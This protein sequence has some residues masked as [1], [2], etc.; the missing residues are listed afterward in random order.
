MKKYLFPLLV[1]CLFLSGCSQNSDEVVGRG[2]EVDIYF[3]KWV[4]NGLEYTLVIKNSGWKELT[5]EMEKFKVFTEYGDGNGEEGSKIENIDSVKSFFGEGG[6]ILYSGEERRINGVLE[7]DEDFFKDLL[8]EQIIFFIEYS[9]NFKTEQAETLK[10][11][12]DVVSSVLSEQSA[13]VFVE[14]WEFKKEGNSHFLD[15]VL[16]LKE[17]PHYFSLD[18]SSV[19]FKI[20]G[21]EL[22]IGSCSKLTKIS[23]S[24]RKEKFKLGELRSALLNSNK[25]VI[26]CHIKDDIINSY[27]PN[28]YTSTLVFAD[29]EYE[30][31]ERIQKK[32]VFP[33]VRLVSTS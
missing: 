15:I 1:C 27:P 2:L 4:E 6:V 18:F 32:I 7:F 14:L 10:I 28:T 21:S 17:N 20:G 9:Y 22:E 25:V 8:N 5:L 16:S 12:P 24:Y 19:E 11:K 30:V 26:Q 13:P 29:I 23:D 3:D 31:T 33:E